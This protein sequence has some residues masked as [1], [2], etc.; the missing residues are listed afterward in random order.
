LIEVGWQGQEFEEG[1]LL[2]AAF[3]RYFKAQNQE[4]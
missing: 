1:S 4:L 3:S 2:R